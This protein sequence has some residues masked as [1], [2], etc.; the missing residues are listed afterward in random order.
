MFT[1]D[2]LGALDLVGRGT[3]PALLAEFT[4]TD[5]SRD[6]NRNMVMLFTVASEAERDKGN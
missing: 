1:F 6:E 4:Q 2:V 3:A 5:S